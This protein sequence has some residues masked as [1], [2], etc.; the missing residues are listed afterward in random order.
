M[1]A[2][3]RGHRCRPAAWGLGAERRGRGGAGAQ[4]A[5]HGAREARGDADRRGE[6]DAEREAGDQEEERAGGGQV[7]ARHRAAAARAPPGDDHVHE[8]E[9][10]EQRHEPR[11]VRDALEAGD[12]ERAQVRR[13]AQR[14][15]RE[16]G[17]GQQRQ[18]GER[19]A[20]RRGRRATRPGER[21]PGAGVLGDERRRAREDLV[22]G[23]GEAH[24][25]RRDPAARV[26]DEQLD[27]VAV[28]ERA[29]E[30]DAETEAAA[31]RLEARGRA[32]HPMIVVE[33]QAARG[34]EAAEAC[35]GVVGRVVGDRRRAD[36]AGEPGVLEPALEA[37]EPGDREGAL[38]GVGAARVEE[39]D[40]R[41][42][43]G[44][45]LA[46]PDRPAGV[47][48][49]LERRQLPGLAAAVG[50][51][52]T[53][54][55][56]QPWRIAAAGARRTFA[57]LARLEPRERL[58]ELAGRG[59]AAPRPRDR[60][61]RL[62]RDEIVAAADVAERAGEVARQRRRRRGRP[63]QR[64]RRRRDQVRV[65]AAL[66]LLEHV[67]QRGRRQPDLGERLQD[68]A[69]HLHDHRGSEVLVDRVRLV[70]QRDELVPARRRRAD[71]VDE[72]RDLLDRRD[73]RGFT[74]AR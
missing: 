53:G 34:A 45:E 56:A 67:R 46:V 5:E 20:R 42:P 16:D 55:A 43:A 65:M 18:D 70:E 68:P 14:A 54:R 51:D 11:G 29:D 63:A 10:D 57:R 19:G 12:P 40:D 38:P 6:R 33:A 52:V 2:R 50:P 3:R 30:A 17:E 1:P 48:L 36:A 7:E 72:R 15:L 13:P 26:E 23:P 66:E 71:L 49:E 32:Q 35:R 47:I 64:A 58:E 27:P 62:E 41:R 69:A 59:R 25:R 73:H 8:D 39:R 37:R 22:L 24:E 60:A 9:G 4:A 28:D 74:R 31:Q 44:E 61:E 21:A